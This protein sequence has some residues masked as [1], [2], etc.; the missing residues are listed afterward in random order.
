MQLQLQV[1]KQ[2]IE[3]AKEA[4]V[5]AREEAL[6]QQREQLEKEKN[7]VRRAFAQCLAPG[8]R[9]E[10]CYMTV[11]VEL[12]DCTCTYILKAIMTVLRE[13]MGWDETA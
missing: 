13:V 6:L 10:S 2:Q 7:E 1:L 8:I 4:S 5:R 11:I 3:A 9:Y 12:R